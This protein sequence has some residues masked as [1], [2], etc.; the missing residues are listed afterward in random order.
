MLMTRAARA[1]KVK[2]V[3][4]IEES[5]VNYNPRGQRHCVFPAEF[6]GVHS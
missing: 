2:F 6:Q 3:E 4:Q 5:P 1:A